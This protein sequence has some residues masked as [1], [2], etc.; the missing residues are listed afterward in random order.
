LKFKVIG[1]GSFGKVYLVQKKDNK[2]IYALKALK[3]ED[4][5]KRNQTE[6]AKGKFIGRL[7]SIEGCL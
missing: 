2:Q 3:K 7:W 6:N 5:L 1:R 4:I